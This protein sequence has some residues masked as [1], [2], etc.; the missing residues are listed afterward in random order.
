MEN[1]VF[2][3]LRKVSK[4]ME[5]SDTVWQE[6]YKSIRKFYNNKIIIIDNNSDNDTLTTSVHLENC[7]IIN[8]KYYETRLFA[9]FHFLINFD[10]N[11][12]IILHDGC[13][14]QNF[15]DFSKFKNVKFIW[16]FDM[17][18]Y[19]DVNNI[20]NQLNL[21]TNND[22][23]QNV[24]RK[25]NFTGCMGCCLAIEKEFLMH[26]EHKHK[27][28]NLVN[29]INNQ[30]SAIAFERTISIICFSLYPNLIND[31]S[32]EGEIKKMVW[33]YRY[34][35]FVDNVKVFKCVEWDTQKEVE[36]DISEKSI[37]KIFG[38]RK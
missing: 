14:F 31:L 1:Y 11:R 6:C 8:N 2:V 15:V 5:N 7:E 36:I 18:I 19:D 16:H 34:K 12:A 27:I 4:S 21:L 3:V 9:P 10:F 25:S 35:H 26:I 28:S 38:A 24:F 13:I 17:K 22:D 32:F 30:E 33:G 23:L 37:I 29:I 20:N